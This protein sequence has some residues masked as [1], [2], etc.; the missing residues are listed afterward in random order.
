[1]LEGMVQME[2]QSLWA[3]HHHSLCFDKKLDFA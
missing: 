2:L 3:F 1:M